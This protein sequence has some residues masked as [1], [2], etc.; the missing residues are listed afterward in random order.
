MNSIEALNWRYAT[1]QFDATKKLT[2]EQ[3]DIVTESLRLAPSSYGLQPW[4]FFIVTNP[5]IRAKL[6]EAAYGQSQVTDASEVVV[7]TVPK[8]LD[9]ALVDRYME[10]IAETRS[11]P[12]DSLK[13]MVDMI[14][15]MLAGLSPEARI[16]WA[17]RQVYIAL[18]TMLTTLA[19]ES[20]D[21]C[22][23]EGFNPSQFDEILGLPEQG[24][25]TAVIATIGF[26]S[27]DDK[28][29]TAP[30]VRFAKD[31]VIKEVK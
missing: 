25:T 27:S 14:K 26:R 19:H 1:K 13:G 16:A 31:Q 8:V 23:M 7:F 12:V 29:A 24:L 9:D 2:N 21:A 20:I 17:M 6:R 3:K 4:T 11:I 30:K 28:Y 18:G 10:S 15:G 22:P 5:E